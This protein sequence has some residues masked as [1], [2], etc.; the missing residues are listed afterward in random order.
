M[1]PT[2]TAIQVCVFKG[3]SQDEASLMSLHEVRTGEVVVSK[4]SV[5]PAIMVTLLRLLTHLGLH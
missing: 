2:K 3:E 4:V 1:D 5:L